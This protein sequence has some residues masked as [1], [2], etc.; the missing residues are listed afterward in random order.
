MSIY[1]IPVRNLAINSKR[2]RSSTKPIRLIFY[3]KK[4]RMPEVYGTGFKSA[5][6]MESFRYAVEKYRRGIK[7]MLLVLVVRILSINTLL[8]P[9]LMI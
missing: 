6:E 3:D 4:K 1:R 2:M 9:V 8:K 7:P 5:D